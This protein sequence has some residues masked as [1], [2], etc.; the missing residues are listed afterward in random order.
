MDVHEFIEKIETNI[1]GITPGSLT[2][3]TVFRDLEQWD[4]LADLMLLAMV[5]SDYDVAISGAELR[6]FNTLNDIINFIISKKQ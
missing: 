3:E 2:P 4:S 5:D 1:D 6:S